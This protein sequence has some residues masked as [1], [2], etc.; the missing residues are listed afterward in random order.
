M[1]F[2]ETAIS[3]SN[4]VMTTGR[5][6][7]LNRRPWKGRE[8]QLA[9]AAAMIQHIFDSRAWKSWPRLHLSSPLPSFWPFDQLTVWTIACDII[10]QER[11]F[12]ILMSGQG[13]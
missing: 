10:R 9:A 1:R 13:F 8:C 12:L 6:N 2:E 11:F 3:R 4:E 7:S 5:V